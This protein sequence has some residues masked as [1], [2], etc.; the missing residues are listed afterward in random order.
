MLDIQIKHMFPDS[1][2]SMN[3]SLS[4]KCTGIT[5]ISGPSGSGKSTLLRAIAG[6]LKP[7]VGCIYF[8]QE[9]WQDNDNF[10]PTHQR[11]VAYVF[12]EGSLL[13]HL[14]GLDNINYGLKRSQ[15]KSKSVNFDEVIDVLGIKNQ[16]SQLPDQMSGGERQRVA[17]ASAVI[18]G[19]KVLLMDEP[20]ASLD[21]ER[22]QKLISYFN[23]IKSTFD[24]PIIYVTHS[25][26]E[27]YSLADRIILM[28]N[29]TIQNQDYSTDENYLLQTPLNIELNQKDSNQICLSDHN[30]RILRITFRV[31]QCL[32]YQQ[33]P[34]STEKS[35]LLEVTVDSINKNSVL[36]NYQSQILN[37]P[38]TQ[39]VNV[40]Q[41]LWLLCANPQII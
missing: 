9:V 23:K 34:I 3:L 12:Q 15:L 5:A 6:L 20:L 29:G 18:R 32:L 14:S 27:I 11:F 17:I 10:I 8:N 30:N 7:D 24:I 36:L 25:I 33:K 40:G 4:L 28:N 26:D 2:F 41:T 37:F 19:A 38:T 31:D 39:T 21:S 13:P 1:K 22:K 16:L 35:V